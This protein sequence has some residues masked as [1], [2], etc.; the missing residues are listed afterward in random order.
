MK[1]LAACFILFEMILSLN[2][3]YKNLKLIQKLE[4]HMEKSGQIVFQQNTS[5][6]D[7]VIAILNRSKELIKAQRYDQAREL[8]KLI[9][10][11][12]T[13]QKWLTKIDE[14]DDPFEW[15][16]VQKSHSSISPSQIHTHIYTIQQPAVPSRSKTTAAIIA[17]FL[18]GLGAHHFYLG[19]V[20]E[21]T[22]YLLFCW[23]GIPLILSLIDLVLIVSTSDQKWL[24]KY[25]P[26]VS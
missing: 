14:L 24:E 16:Q 3:Y 11:H 18:G 19:K 9:P 8:L 7:H 2:P 10:Q 17:L 6:S 25:P 22:L 4:A 21:G 12:P 23:T 13:A 20:G 5:E 26:T 1:K 15:S